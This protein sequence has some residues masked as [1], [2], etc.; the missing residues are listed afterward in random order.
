MKQENVTNDDGC[1]VTNDLDCG[2]MQQIITDSMAVCIR[3]DD[4]PIDKLNSMKLIITQT[5]QF[6]LMKGFAEKK[7]PAI[8]IVSSQP[9]G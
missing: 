3:Q 2:Y 6:S 7:Q 4:I 8:S 1:L 9:Q 5:S